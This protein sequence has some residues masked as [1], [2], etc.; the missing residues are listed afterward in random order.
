VQCSTVQCSAVQCSR[1]ECSSM[2]E[3]HSIVNWA[4]K[5]PEWKEDATRER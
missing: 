5:I 4:V 2:L 3:G 1:L